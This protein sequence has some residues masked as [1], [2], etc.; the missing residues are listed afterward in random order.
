MFKT[1]ALIVALGMTPVVGTA[2]VVAQGP[3]P[4][5]EEDLAVTGGKILAIDNDNWQ[6]TLE[7]APLEHVEVNWDGETAFTLDG[8]SSTQ[9]EV[10]VAERMV[11]VEHKDGLAVTVRG[12]TEQ[13]DPE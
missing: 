11:T 9:A 6:F 8:E 1:T 7:V 5:A 4:V 2:V 13:E 10:L 12:M 3:T